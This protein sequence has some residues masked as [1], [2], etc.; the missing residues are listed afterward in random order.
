MANNTRACARWY[1][2]PGQGDAEHLRFAAAHLHPV[3]VAWLDRRHPGLRRPG[4]AWAAAHY[5]YLMLATAALRRLDGDHR[6]A[7][8]V[9]L[10]LVGALL[11]V[12]L[13]RAR[14]APWFG[15]VFYT[16]L[17]FGHAGTALWPI[18]PARS[19][20]RGNRAGSQP[21]SATA[22]SKA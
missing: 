20:P 19:M 3:L 17:L 7:A 2:R 14:V 18:Q 1:E 13:G 22:L 21:R 16:K 8:A 5:G 4:W 6:R 11:D 15:T 10:T 9:V 12:P